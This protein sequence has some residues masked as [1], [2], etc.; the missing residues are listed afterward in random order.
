MVITAWKRNHWTLNIHKNVNV[1]PPAQAVLDESRR[2]TNL[3]TNCLIIITGKYSKSFVRRRRWWSECSRQ[4]TYFNGMPEAYKA[5]V[6]RHASLPIN[7]LIKRQQLEFSGLCMPARRPSWP[8][9]ISHVWLSWWGVNQLK[10]CHLTAWKTR[11]SSLQVTPACT[12]CLLCSRL[13]LSFRILF[14][15]IISS[16][17]YFLIDF[18]TQNG[19]QGALASS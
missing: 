14:P 13:L 5:L 16:E 7:E 17:N 1:I 3:I 19:E 12:G 15:S 11:P 18:D 10:S 6:L 9:A 2:K 4:T 8:S